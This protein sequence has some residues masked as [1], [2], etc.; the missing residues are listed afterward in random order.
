MGNIP[1]TV[2]VLVSWLTLNSGILVL[3]KLSEIYWSASSLAQEEL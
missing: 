1:D 3:R 2:R